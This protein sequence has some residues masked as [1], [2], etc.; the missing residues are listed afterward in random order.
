MPNE[1]C[2]PVIPPKLKVSFCNPKLTLG[3][4]NDLYFGNAANPFA[5]WTSLSEWNTR[6]DNDTLDDATKIRFLSIIGSKPKPERTKIPYSQNRNYHTTPVHTIPFKVDETSQE[7]YEFL[8]FLDEN[9]EYSPNVW[10]PDADYL[11]GGNA[12]IPVSITMDHIIT[13]SDKELNYFEGVIEWTDK[14]PVRIP[15]P[16]A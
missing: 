1:I 11:Y 5:D 3:R 12:G 14:H 4:I 13:E 7:N 8:Q 2:V 10:Y 9:P 6:L 15:N 16:L